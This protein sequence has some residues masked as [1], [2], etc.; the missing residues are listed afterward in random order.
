MGTSTTVVYEK[1]VCGYRAILCNIHPSMLLGSMHK[2]KFVIMSTVVN[3]CRSMYKKSDLATM[4]NW[5]IAI[6]LYFRDT[7]IIIANSR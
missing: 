1:K 6:F 2:F 5:I 3:I 4:I 7:C